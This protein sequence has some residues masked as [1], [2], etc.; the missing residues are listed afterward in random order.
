MPLNTSFYTIGTVS[1]LTDISVNTIRTWERRYFKTLSA[2]SE[3]GRRLY[4]DYAVNKL[5]TIKRLSDSG[6]NVRD[7]ANLSLE[8]LEELVLNSLNS[9]NHNKSLSHLKTKESVI[10]TGTYFHGRQNYYHNNYEVLQ[11]FNN[12]NELLMNSEDNNVERITHLI[13]YAEIKGA[14]IENKILHITQHFKNQTVVMFYDFAPRK[15]L[16]LLFDKGIEIIRTN[17]P[18]ILIDRYLREIIR[19]H[20]N[21]ESINPSDLKELPKR[22]LSESQLYYLQ[23]VTSKIEC[24]CPNHLSYLGLS[25]SAFVEYSLNC[26]N[27]SEKD[28][29][30]HQ[31]LAHNTANALQI[32]EET[33]IYLC[34]HENI[35]LPE[36]V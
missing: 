7:L 23:E 1:Q 30:V 16:Q 19:N 31:Q 28:R 36:P 6:M 20:A 22:L 32:I 5:K 11:V 21:I 26:I 27:R 17:V 9:K 25:L 15:E 14:D 13:D 18:N 10:L 8:K 2:R 34:K 12:L 29:L 4:D 3:S 35:E 24:E 33:I